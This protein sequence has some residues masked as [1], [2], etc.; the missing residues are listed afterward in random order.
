MIASD[1]AVKRRVGRPSVNIQPEQV[2]ELK[3][4]DVSW[5]RIGKA[6][7]IGTATAMRLFKSIERARPNTQDVRPRTLERIE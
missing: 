6:L 3:R 4:Q 1:A 2:D 7:G 5:R